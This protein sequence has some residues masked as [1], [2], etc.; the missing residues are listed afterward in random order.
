MAGLHLWAAEPADLPPLAA[1]LQDAIGRAGDIGYDRGRRR[2]ALVIA[3]YRWEERE[4]SRVRALLTIGGV[5]GV[6]RTHWPAPATPLD[7]LT[8]RPEAQGLRLDFA[9][10]AALA[11]AT[12]CLDI[13]LDDVG[14]A[15]AARRVPGHG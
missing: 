11:L 10:G 2:V 4:P 3:R 13:T 9:G 8:L 7:L 5:L 15:W 1:L 6:R 14:E 12:E